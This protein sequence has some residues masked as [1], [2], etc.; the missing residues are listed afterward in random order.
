MTSAGRTANATT[1]TLTKKPPAPTNGP[2][3][4]KTGSDCEPS[5]EDSEPIT[6][7]AFLKLYHQRALHQLDACRGL[8]SCAQ[9][10]ATGPEP[11]YA[12]KWL[13]SA[14]DWVDSA[15]VKYA[16]KLNGSFDT[17]HL[18]TTGDEHEREVLSIQ[19][20]IEAA[21]RRAH[22][23]RGVIPDSTRHETAYRL[24]IA[25]REQW[26]RLQH[27][28]ADDTEQLERAGRAFVRWMGEQGGPDQ[29]TTLSTACRMEYEAAML[30]L[31]RPQI[32]TN[33]IAAGDTPTVQ[34]TENAAGLL[35][36]LAKRSRAETRT[37]IGTVYSMHKDA[38]RAN[39]NELVSHGFLTDHGRPN[40]LS[41]NQRGRAWLSRQQLPAE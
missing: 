7:G 38:V 29:L 37:T 10:L 39:V 35:E 17:L 25:V 16:T 33:G 21:L 40:G 34:L 11:G 6:P 2:G 22:A 13:R 18:L 15:A 30:D 20:G 5:A 9:F 26:R 27:T 12:E 8:L 24:A 23:S 3:G 32:A 28:P 14:R 19:D 1:R 4:G 36:W 41:V 31:E